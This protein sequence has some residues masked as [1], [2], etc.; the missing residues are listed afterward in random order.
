M[1][2]IFNGGEALPIPLAHRW[3]RAFE[4]TQ[5]ANTYGMTESAINATMHVTEHQ[6]M[7]AHTSVPIGSPIPNTTAYVLDGRLEPV[8]VGVAGELWVRGRGGAGAGTR[9]GRG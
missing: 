4:A 6:E 7:G 2:W 8:P 3:Y 5:L 1:S 9:T